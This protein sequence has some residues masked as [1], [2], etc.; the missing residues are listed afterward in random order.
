[1]EKLMTPK[2]YHKFYIGYAQLL[3]AYEVVKKERDELRKNE[4]RTA[5]PGR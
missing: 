2:E 1:M 5:S 3:K 4:R